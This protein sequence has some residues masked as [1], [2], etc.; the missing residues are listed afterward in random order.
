MRVGQCP[1]KLSQ[2][3]QPTNTATT[4]TT[5]Q[6]QQHTF[7]PAFIHSA[8]TFA[9][10]TTTACPSLL[11]TAGTPTRCPRETIV[12][13]HLGLALLA[14]AHGTAAIVA[15]D[16]TLR[17]R[18][19]YLRSASH[20][21]RARPPKKHGSDW[22][23]PDARRSSSV[24]VLCPFTV[25]IVFFWRHAPHVGWLGTAAARSAACIKRTPA[26]PRFC[27][28]LSTAT[29]APRQRQRLEVIW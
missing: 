5:R 19:S 24:R 9:F 13:R 29:G 11:L 15:G 28:S 16:T 22:L 6:D 27:R 17:G 23:P 21:A 12:T 14:V 20:R 1:T 3:S 25:C 10:S 2:G 26:Y 18:G 7:Q 8:A 4:T